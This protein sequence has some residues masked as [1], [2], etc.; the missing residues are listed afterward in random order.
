MFQQSITDKMPK[1]DTPGNHFKEIRAINETIEDM[2]AVGGYV[3]HAKMDRM[4]SLLLDHFG[5]R[6]EGDGKGDLDPETTRVMVFCSFRDCVEEIVVRMFCPF[7][8]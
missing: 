1:K 5:P 2:K 7:V 6:E 8:F 4:K 3:P